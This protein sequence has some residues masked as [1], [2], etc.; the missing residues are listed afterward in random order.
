MMGPVYVVTDA[1]APLHVADQVRAAAQGGASLIQLRDKHAS[2][3]D[4]ASLIAAVLPELT[5]RGVKLVINDRVDLAITSGAH[6]L[7]IGQ[8]DGDPS[9]IRQRIGADMLLG[10]SVEALDQ[11][12][13]IPVGVD[14]I[15]VGPVRATPSK[16]DH[17]TPIGFDGLARIIAA[18]KLPCYAI[19][20]V[21]PG[22]AA[23]VKAAG[24]VGLAVVS[25][26][27]RAV[28][29]AA[30]TRALLDEWNAA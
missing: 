5:A 30:A 21:K 14:Y 15:G 12:Q 16:P 6:G 23:A 13:R 29:P 22:D 18:T 17:A 10:L 20:G 8:G 4:L 26:V 24:A 1:K 28:D 2:D 27:T 3:A 9:L 19:G 11:V 7:H 25:A